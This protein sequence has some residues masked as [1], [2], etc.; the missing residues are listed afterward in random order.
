MLDHGRC[1]SC[2]ALARCSHHAAECGW[3]G[4]GAASAGRVKNGWVSRARRGVIL[5]G[6]GV[7][8]VAEA[9]REL[10]PRYVLEDQVEPGLGPESVPV[11]R[12]PNGAEANATREAAPGV[13]WLVVEL[14]RPKSV[15]EH[16]SEPLLALNAWR[17][18][19]KLIRRYRRRSTSGG[20]I[21]PAATPRPRSHDGASPYRDDV[22]TR[23]TIIRNGKPKTA[24]KQV[25]GGNR[26]TWSSR[27]RSVL[28]L[29]RRTFG[30]ASGQ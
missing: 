20:P 4:V 25:T 3:G 1:T 13:D 24:S 9:L 12:R 6:Y 28:D 5:Y 17:V 16:A 10:D 29:T 26:R 23:S 30:A 7:D 2:T 18:G 27:V 21:G 22:S 8:A 14:Y 15:A 11:V 19:R